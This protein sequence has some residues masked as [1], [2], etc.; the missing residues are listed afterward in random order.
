MQ[1]TEPLWSSV[2]SSGNGSIYNTYSQGSFLRV[3]AKH[4]AHRLAQSK[5]AAIPLSLLG[6]LSKDSLEFT[7]I[8]P[9]I[10]RTG[11]CK[12]RTRWGVP[13]Q[14]QTKNVISK[15][16]IYRDAAA[17]EQ[18]KKLEPEARVQDQSQEK[19]TTNLGRKWDQI[20]GK[21]GDEREETALLELSTQVSEVTELLWFK[22]PTWQQ[23]ANEA[24]VWMSRKVALAVAWLSSQLCSFSNT[25]ES[26]TPST[27]AAHLQTAHLRPLLITSPHSPS[28]PWKQRTH[29]LGLEAA[30]PAFQRPGQREPRIINNCRGA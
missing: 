16:L 19:T 29:P 24:W 26:S 13:E 2:S 4:T 14:C 7:L 11:P 21:P 22:H 28:T 10:S 20:T 17:P 6:A 15:G 30:T 8:V 23:G 27:H 9:V 1:E 25:E 18:K 5:P 12:G 3:H